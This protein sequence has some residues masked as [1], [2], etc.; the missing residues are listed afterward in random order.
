METQYLAP[1]HGPYCKGCGHPLVLRAL[2]EALAR[3]AIAPANV[4]VV[5]DI[6]CVGLADGQIAGPHTIHTTHGRSTAFAAGLA[7]ADSVLGEGRLKPIVLIGD[8]GATIGIN[9][10]VSG[11]LLNPD[12]TVLVHNNFLY[13]MTGGQSSAFTP[14]DFVTSTAPQGSFVP[15]LDL[16]RVLLAARAPFVAR[17]L[18]GD[19][20]LVDVLERAIA[21]PG[22]AAVEILRAVHR[23]CDPLESAHRRNA[24]RGHRASRLRARRPA[25]RAAPHVR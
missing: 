17:K 24:A 13:G 18:S 21:H 7:L 6:G 9:H 25:R 8:G 19:R 15:P 5:T 11:A 10:L 4:A 23:V 14:V 3:L 22:F 1:G 20:D 12:V 2:G 16:A